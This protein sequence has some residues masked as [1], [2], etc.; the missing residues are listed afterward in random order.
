MPRRRLWRE[1]GPDE[2]RE[3]QRRLASAEAAEALGDLPVRTSN[4]SKYSRRMPPVDDATR[5]VGSSVAEEAGAIAADADV[6]SGHQSIDE[7]GHQLTVDVAAGATTVLTDV[8]V[9]V[10]GGGGGRTAACA[11]V[12]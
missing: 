4:E 11:R 1:E 6:G 9:A 8:G 2:E 12:R 3:S 5:A 7:Y 10:G